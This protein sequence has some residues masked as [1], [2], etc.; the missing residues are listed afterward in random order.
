MKYFRLKVKLLGEEE[1]SVCRGKFQPVEVS[2][3]DENYYQ[4]PARVFLCCQMT[5]GAF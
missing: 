3:N 5:T 2:T 4:G 1:E